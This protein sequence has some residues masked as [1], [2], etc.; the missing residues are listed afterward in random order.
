MEMY[1]TNKKT[2]AAVPAIS[3]AVPAE[4]VATPVAPAAE[5]AVPAATPAVPAVPAVKCGTIL[6]VIDQRFRTRVMSDERD[7]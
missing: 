2:P 1:R 3:A 6:F 4:P 7:K 5:P